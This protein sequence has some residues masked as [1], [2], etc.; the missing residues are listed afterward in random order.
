MD[1][2]KKEK[3][4][5]LRQ[6]KADSKNKAENKKHEDLL[7]A[8][9]GLHSLF[10]QQDEKNA[11]N[12]E[13]LLAEL[14]KFNSFKDEVAKVREAIEN[15]P[16]KDEV[17]INN[18]SELIE[19]QKEVDF[20]QLTNAV[21][22]LTVAVKNQTVDSVGIKNKDV[23][24]YIPVRRVIQVGKRLVFD[25]KPMEVSVVGGGSSTPRIKAVDG[26]SAVPIANPDGTY[27]SGGSGGGG[28]AS[29]AKQDEQTALLTQIEDNTANIKIDADSVNLNTDQIEAK[30]DTIASQ[31]QQDALT[32]SQLRATPLPVNGTIALDSATLAAL[33]NITVAVS[34]GEIA[35]DATT[36]A[37]LESI[38]VSGTVELGSATLAALETIN[39]V[40]SGTVALDSA[41]LTALENI[42]ATISGSVTV[43]KGTGWVDPQTDAL[44]DAQLRASPV[45][46]SASIDT[47]GLATDT[48]QN[49]I[50]SLLDDG[51]TFVKTTT[52]A[53]ASGNN[54]IYTPASGKF[55]RLY[56]FGYSAG[57][58]VTGVL[59]G[60]R[61]G[62]SGT[63]FDKQ[64]LVAAGQPYARNIQAGKRYIDG[65]V[66]EPLIVNLDA[67]QTVYV[68][69]EIEEI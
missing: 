25:D 61:F 23:E 54:T 34:S 39:A 47:T 59:A 30:L 52:A 28:D 27:I 55:I 11:Q 1:K 68:N 66:D 3:L 31:Q 58:N 26:N 9:R 35:L 5:E 69:I 38:I 29:A 7:S 44:T 42:T 12:T 14:E 36:L 57:A 13:A 60:L 21:K 2:A 17:S 15:I 53:T 46:V 56:F 51:S 22:T 62:T 32:D 41:T 6:K 18:L 64:Y 43:D 50:I 16:Q 33:E 40:V 49:T 63:I 65:A 19:S 48:N 10:D 37:A 45:P 8:V 4:L 67:T 24:D 20:T